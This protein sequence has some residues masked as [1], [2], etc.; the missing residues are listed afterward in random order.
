MFAPDPPLRRRGCQLPLTALQVAIVLFYIALSALTFL[1][2]ALCASAQAQAFLYPLQ[3]ALVGVCTLSY[4]VC[5]TL[6]V[7]APGG[8][9]CACVATSQAAEPH[10]CRQTGGH[11]PG[12][13]HFC[14]FMNVAVGKRTYFW[15]YLM[16]ATG[17]L[18]FSWQ[19]ASLAA[20]AG[21]PWLG[22]AGEAGSPLS[23]PSK[24]AFA[25]VMAFLGLAG[26]ASF[27]PLC[28][29]HTCVCGVCVCVEGGAF[30]PKPRAGL[31]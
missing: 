22:A 13:D 14:V 19:V 31:A 24:Q 3:G 11:V 25:G 7:T 23:Q 17:L 27:G 28:A 21:G 12:Y 26:I 6:D 20:V 18:Q 8:I 30:E 29:F 16:A 2:I 5:N 10:Y 9:P 15:F 1:A 4:L